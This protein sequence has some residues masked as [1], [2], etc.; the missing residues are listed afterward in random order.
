VDQDGEWH[1]VV[2]DSTTNLRSEF[3]TSFKP[4]AD[5]EYVINFLRFDFFNSTMSAESRIDIAYFGMDSDL[6]K[7]IEIN[8]DVEYITYVEGETKYKLITETGEIVGLGGNSTGNVTE[9]NSQAD[10][11]GEGSAYKVSDKEY[12]S[13]LDMINGRGENGEV[14]I[15][16]TSGNSKTG[17]TV[18]NHN[19]ST[20]GE[21]LMIFS[22][23]CVVNGG[24]SKYVW[25]ADG[26]VTWND[27]G[28]SFYSNLRSASQGVLDS[29]SAKLGITLE[30]GSEY[31]AMFQ[32]SLN[33]PDPSTV[34]GV[35]ADLSDFA[36]Q[37]VN[38]TLAAVPE[39]AQDTLCVIAY[40]KNITV[41]ETGN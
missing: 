41:P 36:G 25:S 32:G 11:I 17:V 23:W 10:Y 19:G 13:C 38:V 18:F 6:D 35:V 22:G 37:T 3:A 27:T 9:S 2:I 12:F 7:I 31:N 26:G 29:A 20:V 16:R 5:G 24:V 40:V 39:T 28:L 15:R 34:A 30:S 1:V 4:N 14:Y 21:N 8:K 33:P